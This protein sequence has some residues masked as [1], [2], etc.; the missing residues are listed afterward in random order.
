M[1]VEMMRD[2]P[3]DTAVTSVA[4]MVEVGHDQNG[5]V[6]DVACPYP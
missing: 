1:T 3:E 5:K 2:G 6:L 4:V